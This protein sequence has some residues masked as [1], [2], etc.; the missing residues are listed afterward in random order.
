VH[1]TQ[2]Q[3]WFTSPE[4]AGPGAIVFSPKA[5]G[6]GLAQPHETRTD[7]RLCA[8]RLGVKPPARAVEDGESDVP[9]EVRL[10]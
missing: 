1:L 6:K 7:R 9:V 2:C 4:A 5:A 10:G 8:V 3:E